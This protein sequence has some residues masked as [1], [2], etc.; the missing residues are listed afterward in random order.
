MSLGSGI[1]KVPDT[2]H[3]GIAFL[4]LGETAEATPS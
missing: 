1:H 4:E 3:L 2:L